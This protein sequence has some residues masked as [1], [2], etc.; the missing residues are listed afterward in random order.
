MAVTRRAP[1][2]A[3]PCISYTHVLKDIDLKPDCSPEY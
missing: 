3:V 1:P 2:R